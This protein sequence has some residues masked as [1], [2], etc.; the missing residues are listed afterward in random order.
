MEPMKLQETYPY[1]AILN[2]IPVGQGNA[3]PAGELVRRIGLTDTRQLR[4]MIERLRGENECICASDRGYFLPKDKEEAGR[5]KR[6]M[7]CV[8]DKYDDLAKSANKFLE[9]Q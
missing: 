1:N 3:I 5:W 9:D 2:E 8:R 7:L 4:L 6:H